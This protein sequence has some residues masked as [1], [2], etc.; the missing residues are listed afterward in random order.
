MK[1]FYNKIWEEHIRND[2]T[3]YTEERKKKT[4]ELIR[5]FLKNNCLDCGCGAGIGMLTHM[6]NEVVPTKGIDISDIAIDDAKKRYP[7]IE[8]KC[9][10]ATDIDFPDNSF[11]TLFVSE[12]VEHV[13]DTLKMFSEFKRILKKGGNLIIIVPEYNLFKNIIIALFKW[14]ET[15]DPI[16]EHVRYYSKKSIKKVLKQFG[17]EIIFQKTE[18]QYLILPR[19]ILVVARR[20]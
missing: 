7:K 17:F 13:P 20:C 1:E 18:K 12:T 6:L 10:S 5:P 4:I 2:V 8:F 9:C 14:E 11:N 16:G 19:H 15:F 3:N